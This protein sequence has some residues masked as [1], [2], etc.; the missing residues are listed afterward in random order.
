M[1]KNKF[2][3]LT[4]VDGVPDGARTITLLSIGEDVVSVENVVGGTMIKSLS[5][6][7]VSAKIEIHCYKMFSLNF[8]FLIFYSL[9]GIDCEVSDSSP[10]LYKSE[11]SFS[12][13][14]TLVRIERSSG[15][16]SCPKIRNKYK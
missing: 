5:L 8:F 6:L 14:G 13:S 1:Y 4:E 7:T 12:F 2:S 10:K 9:S 3:T 11:M 15:S 16:V